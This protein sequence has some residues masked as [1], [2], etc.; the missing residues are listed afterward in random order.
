M[1]LSAR[2]TFAADPHAVHAMLTDPEFLDFACRRMG[3]SQFTRQ[4]SPGATQV[5]TSAPA[6]AAV[7]GFL[8]STMRLVQ[9]MTFSDAAADGSRTGTISLTVQ[10]APL[11]LVGTTVLSPTA[12][13][14]VLDYAGELSVDI[15]LLGRR[16]E[17]SAAPEILATLAE[18][19]RLATEWLARS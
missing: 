5:T 14:S 13:G 15:P 18:Q 8:G 17:Q 4:A 2:H 6:P 12:S 7:A 19:E 11:R 16:I 10:G 1:H 3:A 9:A